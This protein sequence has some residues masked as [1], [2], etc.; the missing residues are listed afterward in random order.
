MHRNYTYIFGS[1]NECLV[2]RT[3]LLFP[4]TVLRTLLPLPQSLSDI[5][6]SKHLLD[7]FGQILANVF[8]PLFEVTLDPSS[9]PNLNK[10]LNQ[11]RYVCACQ[12]ADEKL[13]EIVWAH[14]YVVLFREDLLSLF[15]ARATDFNGKSKRFDPEIFFSGN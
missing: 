14:C 9:H 8:L 11:V 12:C 1:T 4:M 5:Y 2:Y 10:F 15:V 3:L 13:Q 7:N 6:H